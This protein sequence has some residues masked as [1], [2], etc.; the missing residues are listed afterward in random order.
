MTKYEFEKIK[1]V[2][3]HLV[4][5]RIADIRE[6]QKKLPL[7]EAN[8]AKWLKYEGEISELENLNTKYQ[9]LTLKQ[10]HE[11]AKMCEA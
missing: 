2:A 4:K 7:D 8:K 9:S 1:R 6:F 11:I 3:N 10:M 5:S